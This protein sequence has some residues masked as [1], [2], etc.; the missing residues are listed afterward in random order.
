MRRTRQAGGPSQ[1][2]RVPAPQ[3][4]RREVTLIG[5]FTHDAVVR[6]FEF[7]WYGVASGFPFSTT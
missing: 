4:L 3:F 2:Q 7:G 5:T 1:A 6:Q